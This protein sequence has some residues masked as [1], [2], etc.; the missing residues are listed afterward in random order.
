PHQYFC[1][2]C[3]TTSSHTPTPLLTTFKAA[4]RK[5]SRA[6]P[7]LDYA[8]LDAH[9]PAD[10]G[11]WLRNL[12]ERKTT[13]GAFQV[14]R[15]EELSGE[16]LRGEMGMVEPFWIERP[17]GLGMKMPDREMSVTE[18]ARIVGPE[19][20]VEVIDVASQQSTK[21]TLADWAAYYD[22]PKRDK[23]KNVISLEVTDSKLSE[24]VEAPQLVRDLDWVEQIWPKELKKPD[25][26]PRVQKYC[27]MSVANCWTIL[28]GGKVFYFIRPTPANLAAYEEWSG[29]TER[30]ESTWLGDQVDQVYK[31]VL[32]T[33]NTMIIPSGWIHAVV[34]SQSPL[35]SPLILLTLP[36]CQY[37]PTDTLVFGGNF[38]HS[39]D[40]D[41]QL[42]VYRIELSTKVPR[43]FRF[44][45]F[46]RLLWYVAQHYCTLHSSTPTP[47]APPEINVRIL[48]GLKVLSDFLIEQTTRI[49]KDAKVSLERK[50]VA[51]ENIPSSVKDPV[52][53]SREFRRLVLRAL[54]EEMDMDCWVPIPGPNSVVS[55]LEGGKE[56]GKASLQPRSHKRKADPSL[57]SPNG[58]SK[59]KLHAGVVG[60]TTT[61]KPPTT[62]RDEGEIISKKTIPVVHVVREELRSDPLKEEDGVRM[63]NIRESTSTQ[64]VVRRSVGEDGWVTV[65]TRRVVTVIERVRIPPPT[66]TPTP[67]LPPLEDVKPFPIHTS[68]S[69]I[70]PTS[71]P[72][73]SGSLSASSSSNFAPSNQPPTT[74]LP[75]PPNDFLSPDFPL[76]S[77]NDILFAIGRSLPPESDGVPG[78][79]R[80]I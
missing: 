55:S 36:S 60:S 38:L 22:S 19:T 72:Y 8:N 51:K 48:N 4:S 75:P 5:S 67:L 18:V 11:K 39:L 21:M 63:A 71:T 76:E 12:N 77:E 35:F 50:R 65:E 13:E 57:A 54:G 30:Q 16:W 59:L 80:I 43:K 6:A 47:T 3:I 49:G 62:K 15:V 25:T 69:D 34:R 68:S 45:H 73:S 23:V 40:I 14:R 53:V 46:V 74:P 41:R 10:P 28:R 61:T 79:L 24:Q 42:A 66:P 26:Y 17:E 64:E 20:P 27:L 2:P 37:T 56:V 33:G 58:S 1:P 44:P 70:F 29:S 78:E 52:K 32:K 7:K 9:L 31:I